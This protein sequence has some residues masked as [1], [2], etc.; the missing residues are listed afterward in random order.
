MKLTTVAVACVLM[1]AKAA[2]PQTTPTQLSTP[3]KQ[4]VSEHGTKNPEAYELYLKGRSYWDKRTLSDLETAVS[5]FTQAIAKDPDYAQ[6]Y[7]A[8]AS[9]YVVLPDYGGS[10]S[11][12]I[13]KA[14]AAARKALE[15]DATLGRPHAVLA[16]IKFDE[17]DFAG[18]EAEFKKAFVLDPNDATAL[19]WHAE[20][21]GMMGGREQQ[22]LAEINLAHQLDPVSPI[23]RYDVG[24]LHIVARQYDTGIAVCKK[25]A[26]DNPAFAMAHVC[27]ANAYWQ[28][29]L[30]AQSIEELKTYA[31]LYG[32]RNQSELASAM[33]QGFRSA[34]WQGA[35]RKS[36]ESSLAQRKTGY[37]S[38][39]NIATSY[40]QLGDKDLAFQW[41]NTA[42]QEHDG[43]LFG[44]R[45]DYSFDTIRSDPRF[46]ELV[47]KVGLPQ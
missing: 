11:E 15:L 40:A 35:L 26:T 47:R 6:A 24:Y 1:L 19:M 27:L 37:S 9:A 3:E 32:D 38:A 28:K 43:N 25:L 13:P 33:E 18:G 30:Y 5:Y 46:A 14:Q 8:L 42:Y 44:L 21:I 31:Q 39:Y 45:T 7:T 36:I 10:P 23:I 29:H 2:T 20:P 34:G 41:L 12:D 22:A 4:E 17:W 16:Y